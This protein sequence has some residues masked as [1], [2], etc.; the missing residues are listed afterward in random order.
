MLI[1]NPETNI[2]LRGYNGEI[3]HWVYVSKTGWDMDT[4]DDMLVDCTDYWG[5]GRSVKMHWF[6]AWLRDDDGLLYPIP[7]YHYITDTIEVYSLPT[8]NTTHVFRRL[9]SGIFDGALANDP[10]EERIR[11][12]LWWVD[13]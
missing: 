1:N 6:D 4:Y 8:N 2:F 13:D 10:L 11:G 9:P 3:L 12:I 7:Y 5:L